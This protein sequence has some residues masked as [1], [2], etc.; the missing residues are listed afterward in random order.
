[1][2]GESKRGRHS[3]SMALVGETSAITRPLPIEAWSSLGTEPASPVAR[4]C[5]VIGRTLLSS[6]AVRGAGARRS[7]PR[8]RPAPRNGDTRKRAPS[9]DPLDA[10]QGV[11]PAPSARTAL[12]GGARRSPRTRTEEGAEHVGLPQQRHEASVLV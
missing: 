11:G 2:D 10:D 6:V 1:T 12:H 3:H 8:A 7:G 4:P 5:A 9:Y